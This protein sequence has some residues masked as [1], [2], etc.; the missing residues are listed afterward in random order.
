MDK[1]RKEL[2]LRPEQEPRPA[3]VAELAASLVELVCKMD[4]AALAALKQMSPRNP[5]LR[6]E[7]LRRLLGQFVLAD[8]APSALC[9]RAFEA[10]VGAMLKA[11]MEGGSEFGRKYLER[12]SPEMIF[13][14]ATID[15]K[16]Y[17]NKG[18]LAW[19][20]Y[21][22]LAEDYATPEQINKHVREAMGAS[23]D[24]TLNG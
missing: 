19:R 9:T 20:R 8:Q 6:A 4:Q 23:I 3:R 13:Q 17:D 11:L 15:A 14:V 12:M 10:L 18:E 21:K 22:E 1:L 2:G 5:F 16:F 24:V 7:A